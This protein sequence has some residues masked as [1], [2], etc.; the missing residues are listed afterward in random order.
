[1][2]NK[3]KLQK[4]Y[5]A[6]SA[7]AVKNPNVQSWQNHNVTVAKQARERYKVKT[8]SYQVIGNIH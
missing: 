2:S 6:I 5:T 8:F 3:H 7:T 1:M 4:Y